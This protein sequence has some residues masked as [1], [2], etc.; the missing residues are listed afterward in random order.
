MKQ[1][2][3]PEQSRAAFLAYSEGKNW[4]Q[5]A[6]GARIF[7]TIKKAAWNSGATPVAKFEVREEKSLPPLAW[8]CETRENG[9]HFT[10]GPG[11][12]YGDGYIVEGAWDGDFAARDF[13]DSDHFYGSGARL[14]KDGVC[15]FVPPKHCADYLFVLHDKERG[16]TWISNSFNFIFA[17]AGVSLESEFFRAFKAGV[18]ETTNSESALGADRGQPLIAETPSHLMYRMMYHNFAADSR[19][20]INYFPRTPAKIPG[21]SFQDYKRF[22]HEKT[23]AILA[24]GAAKTR[25]FPYGAITTLS[26]GYDSCA[27]S[28]VC[29]ACGVKD[30]VTLDVVT[31]GHNDC[32]SAIAAS[33]GLNC[34]KVASPLGGNT[35]VLKAVMD[36]NTDL[37]EFI[38]TPGL[39]DNVAFRAMEPYFKGNLV[40]SGL[41]GDGCW[42]KAGGPP[43]LAHA[44]PYMKSRM[45]FRLRVGYCLIPVPAF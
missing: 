5:R 23:S 6:A 18:N 34:H 32:G 27:T 28:A 40:F 16:A 26:T 29:A 13:A 12:E 36:R 31:V 10:V 1:G 45:E 35:P 17:R 39:G 24:N 11:V 2:L 41:Y 8:I 43:G 22:L 9:C 20:G 30:A 25:K 37:L 21:A 38:A 7:Q 42:S 4:E 14:D 15:V 19:G 3:T 33:L 44:L